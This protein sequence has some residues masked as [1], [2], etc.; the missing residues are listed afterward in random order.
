MRSHTCVVICRAGQIHLIGKCDVANIGQPIS[1]VLPEELSANKEYKIKVLDV[2]I[3]PPHCIVCTAFPQ[4]YVQIVRAF[5]S[6]LRMCTLPYLV[7]DN[8]I[9]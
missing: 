1:E 3:E 5:I 7:G 8:S 4:E 9:F 6:C 2:I